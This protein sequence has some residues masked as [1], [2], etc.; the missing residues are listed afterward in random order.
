MRTIKGAD[1]LHITEIYEDKI[2]GNAFK[3][4]IIDV[5]ASNA[6]SSIFFAING[7]EKVIALEPF[8]ESYELGE[9]NIKINNLDHKIILLP[10]A[11]SDYD[12]YTDFVISSENPNANTFNPSPYVEKLGIKFEQKIKVPTITLPSIIQ[13]YNI[14]K[15]FLLKM[16]CEGCEYNVLRNLPEDILNRIDNIILEYHN[17]IQDLPDILKRVGFTVEYDNKSTGLMKAYKNN[18]GLI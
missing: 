1:I 13:K 17:Q 3:G 4:V 14:N 9:Y 10:Y 12:G 11:L 15:I 8:P 18:N 5:G 7:A 2:Y 6:D 16:D